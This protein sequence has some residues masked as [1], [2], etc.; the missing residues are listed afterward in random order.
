MPHLG[1]VRN[2][3]SQIDQTV[4]FIVDRLVAHR[5]Q[6]QQSC[7]IAIDG[8]SGVG[9]STLAV[10]LAQ[11]LEA[12]LISGDDFYAGG[13]GIH[14][15]SSE[16]LADMCIDRRRMA[17]VLTTLKAGQKASYHAFDW[18]SFDGSLSEASVIIWPTRTVVVEGVYTN[19]PEL[20]QL[21]DFSILI[22]APDA[23][24]ERRLFIREAS[25]TEWERQW[26]RA[27]DWYFSNISTD[28]EFNLLIDNV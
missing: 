17:S 23:E 15:R 10:Q 1:S 11:W 7:L 4:A 19:H 3:Q 13:T 26:H 22:R 27:E 24:R 14:E 12:A 5:T 16:Q 6:S 28:K 21:I 18:D 9:K 20:R 25:I 2:M 8:R